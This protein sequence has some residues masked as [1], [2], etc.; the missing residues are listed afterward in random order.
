MTSR[1]Y[2]TPARVLH[3]AVAVLAIAQIL[4]GWAADWSERPLSDLF[5]DQHVRVGILIFLLMLLRISWRLGHQPPP[6]PR[7]FPTWQRHSAGVV[8]WILYLLLLA[9][10]VSGYVLWAWSGKSLSFWG[11]G[12]VPILFTGGDDE[13][14]RSVA[15]YAH[16][17]GAYTIS[18]LVLI[19]IGAALHHQFVAKDMS[20]GERMGF[21]PL[22]GNAGAD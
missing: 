3:W 11:V 15:G 10:P 18:A 2:S 14:W 16:E 4:L 7:D 22:D 13:F 6:M 21:G 1:R 8:H 17:Y 5:I 9:M 19:H 12:T 20:I